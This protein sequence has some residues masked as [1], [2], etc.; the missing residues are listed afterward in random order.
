MRAGPARRGRDLPTAAAA[1][2]PSQTSR[3]Y[4]SCAEIPRVALLDLFD[5]FHHAFGVIL[6]Y[7]DLA[8]RLMA[9]LLLRLLVERAQVADID[10]ELLRFDGIEIALEEARRV[11]V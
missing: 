9:G 8:H 11:R 10:H 4:R 2:P 1:W 3:P 5:F 6:P 7:L